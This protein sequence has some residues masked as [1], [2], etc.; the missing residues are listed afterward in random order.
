[1]IGGD[2]QQRREQAMAAVSLLLEPLAVQ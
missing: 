1:M 2:W